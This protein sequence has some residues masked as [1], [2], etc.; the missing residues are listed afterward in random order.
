MSKIYTEKEIESDIARVVNDPALLLYKKNF[1]TRK[2]ITKG[3]NIPYAEIFAR[4][5]I[6]Y[7]IPEKLKKCS[8]DAGEMRKNGYHTNHFL[9]NITFNENPRRRENNI[10]RFLFKFR[11]KNIIPKL[12]KVFD[13]E[14]PL[15]NGDKTNIDL[16]S[17]NHAEKIIYLIEMK[18]DE[19]KEGIM[20]AI[21]EI[22]SY[23]QIVCP[24]KLLDWIKK[25][26]NVSVDYEIKK[27][28]M[29]FSGTPAGDL[30]QNI[31]KLENL[32]RVLE[33]LDINLF[34]LK[35]N[36]KDIKISDETRLNDIKLEL[37]FSYPKF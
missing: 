1:F 25:S 7:G 6:Q 4:E 32:T 2:G 18:S 3:S 13:Y 26:E 22:A 35:K 10:A 37:E 17:I 31:D 8:L 33:I 30:A 21:L 5:I 24:E 20:K 15:R 27:A 19:S 9:S 14:L 29:L 11:Q 28:L 23:G 34:V 16:V 36:F 12:G